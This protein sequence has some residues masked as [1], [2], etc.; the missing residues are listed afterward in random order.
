MAIGSDVLTPGCVY[1]LDCLAGLERLPTDSVDLVF[2][3]PPFNIGYDYDVYDDRRA[4]EDYLQWCRKWMQQIARVLGEHGTFW[5]AIGDEFAAEL[6]LIAQRDC[7]FHCRSW[8]IWYYTFGVHC[9]RGFAR[10][11]THL[12]HFVQDP[13]HFTFEAENPALRVPSARQLVYR[14]RRANP[15]GRLPDNTWILRPQDVPEGFSEDQDVWY[16]ARVAGTFKEREGFHGCQMPEQL[17]GR[18]IRTSSRPDDLVVDPFAGS[19]TTLVVAKKLGRR[20][21]G[22]DISPEYVTR[23]TERIEAAAVGDPLDGPADPA[24]AAPPT[25]KGKPLR[26]AIPP[27][28]LTQM[29]QLV[30]DALQGIDGECPANRV[31][32]DVETRLTFEAK[33]QGLATKKVAPHEWQPLLLVQAALEDWPTSAQG[34]GD[35]T[36]G[37]GDAE[38]EPGVPVTWRE[39]PWRDAV[40]I[41]VQQVETEF[42]RPLPEILLDPKLAQRFDAAV[43]AFGTPKGLEEVARWAG[44]DF[45]RQSGRLADAAGSGAPGP[46]LPAAVPL[47]S[48]ASAIDAAEPVWRLAVVHS[49]APTPLFVALVEPQCWR[50]WLKRLEE[51]PGWHRREASSIQWCEVP[52]HSHALVGRLVETLR[53]ALNSPRWRGGGHRT[54][55]DTPPLYT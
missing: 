41:A 15:R 26:S 49:R 37:E 28:E 27:D 30:A 17:L 24:W 55:W 18:I 32:V 51:A 35:A 40:E 33:L 21:L 48:A 13:E 20:F 19:G 46:R 34:D 52:P 16:Y 11:H 31:L 1:Q 10:S 12:F 44:L 54:L 3:D 7:G 36:L 45:C 42:A 43:N 39:F 53:P 23:A 2:A 47:S 22:F 9:V 38:Y 29:W 14:D 6:K 25:Q 4:A 8:V 50:P 5:L